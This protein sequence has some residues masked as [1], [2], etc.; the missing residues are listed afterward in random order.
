M[1]SFSARTKAN[2][3]KLAAKKRKRGLMAS[4]FKKKKGFGISVTRK[5]R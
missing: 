5:K 1:V 4:V 2:A 3:E